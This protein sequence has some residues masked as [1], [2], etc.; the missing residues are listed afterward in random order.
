MQPKLIRWVLAHEPIEIFI[1]AAERFAEVIEQ[2]VPGQIK[3]EVL[4][5]T[6][7][8][9]KYNNGVTITKHELLDLMEQDKIE[10]SQM[11]TYV[12]SKYNQDLNALDMPFLFKDHE[13][14]ARVFEGPVG[15]ALLAG[16][17]KNNNNIKGMAFTYSGGFKNVPLNKDITSLSELVGTKVR[18]SNS[19]ICAAT[20][21]NLG[22][23][24]VVMD[25]EELAAGMEDGRVNG[26]ESSWPRIYACGQNETSKTILNSDHSLLLTNIIVNTNFF[27]SLSP[28]L[29]AVMEEAAVEAARYERDISVSEVE[30]TSARA[31]KDGIRVLKL[32]D[33]DRVTF[34][35]A[36]AKVYDQFDG[37]FTAGLIDNIRSA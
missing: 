8:A 25:I 21:A 20:F 6:E 13:H 29:Q 33:A 22:A 7:Y 36:A 19:P 3:I 32:S 31:T 24:P 15:K 17:S 26:G 37:Y 11:Y 34:E 12:L 27:K 2:K 30:P 5:L 10:M 16:Y 4:T 23:E 35:K 28:E 18:V 14:A 9:N 1:R